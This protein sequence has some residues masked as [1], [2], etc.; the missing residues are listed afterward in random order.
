MSNDPSDSDDFKE[1][2]ESKW[3]IK[4]NNVYEII[5][6]VGNLKNNNNQVEENC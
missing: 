2:K 6:H 4:G 1:K 5:K 3:V